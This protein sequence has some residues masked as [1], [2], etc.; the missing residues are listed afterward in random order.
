MVWQTALR[1]LAPPTPS[2]IAL[3]S[4]RFSP[5]WMASTEAPISSTS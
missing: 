4:C 3:N 5:R 1:A 2:T